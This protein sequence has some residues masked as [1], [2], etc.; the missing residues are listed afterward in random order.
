MKTTRPAR[1]GFTL[2][3]IMLSVLLLSIIMTIIYGVVVSTIEAAQRVEEIN[4]AGEIGPAILGQMR[5]D[6]EGAFLLPKIPESFV[7]IPKRGT[8]GDRDRIDFVTSRMAYGTRVDGGDPSF[9]SPNEVGYQVVESKTDPS[10]GILYRRQDYFV[11]NE[12]LR[13]G[14]LTELYD[15]VRSF[16]V[17]FWNGQQWMSD[18]NSKRE[19]NTLP[20]AVRIQLKLL[21]SDHDKPV[22]QTFTSV[23]TYPH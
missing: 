8:S 2:V 23:V 5:E 13:G 16:R 4:Q 7:S 6:L 21:V 10:L 11:D 22:E 18:W 1:G 15:R 20:V 19:K 17:E 3:E 9:Q 14:Q 12:P